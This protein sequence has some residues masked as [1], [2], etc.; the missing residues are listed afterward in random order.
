MKDAVT[1]SGRGGIAS[2]LDDSFWWVVLLLSLDEPQDELP[3]C[4][5]YPASQFANSS[6]E[7]K[8]CTFLINSNLHPPAH[9]PSFSVK[10]GT[11]WKSEVGG[12]TTR[13]CDSS[14]SQISHPVVLW[15]GSR[16][17]RVSSGMVPKLATVC[18]HNPTVA[19]ALHAISRISAVDSALWARYTNVARTFLVLVMGTTALGSV[20]RFK[21]VAMAACCSS[22]FLLVTQLISSVKSVPVASVAL[23]AESEDMFC[24]VRR[25]KTRSCTSA[26][27]QAPNSVSTIPGKR[28][29]PVLLPGSLEALQSISRHLPCNVLP[30]AFAT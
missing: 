18:S 27:E 9:K 15:D 3:S 14:Y 10:Q 22:V 29:M 25:A 20:E 21:R 19:S 6:K 7:T 17:R 5:L 8:R 11:G 1:C 24:R 16:T 23:L 4:T 12:T 2:F 26:E 28:V 30:T 13:T